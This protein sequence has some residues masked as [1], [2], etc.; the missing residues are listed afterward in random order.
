MGSGKTIVALSMLQNYPEIREVS[1]L[2]AKKGLIIAPAGIEDGFEFDDSWDCNDHNTDKDDIRPPKDLQQLFPYKTEAKA[3]RDS[4]DIMTIRYKNNSYMS[5][6]ELVDG[7]WNSKRG[8]AQ[9]KKS[10]DTLA[11]TLR[12]KIV[13]VDEAHN[14]IPFIRSNR[15]ANTDM[16]FDAFRGAQRVILMSGTPMQRE[17]S[18]ITVLFNMIKKIKPGELNLPTQDE[19]F[20]A[21]YYKLRKEDATTDFSLISAIPELLIRYVPNKYQTLEYGRAALKNVIDVYRNSV[22]GSYVQ[23]AVTAPLVSFARTALESSGWI[24]PTE[25]G[26]QLPYGREGNTNLF[27]LTLSIMLTN[28]WKNLESSSINPVT[29]LT[30][31]INKFDYRQLTPQ[32]LELASELCSFFDYEVA[33]SNPKGNADE[34]IEPRYFFPKENVIDVQVLLTKKQLNYILSFQ[35]KD[36]EDRPINL[37]QSIK[38]LAV[39]QLKPF[40]I[41]EDYVYFGTK[42]GNLADDFNVNNLPKMHGTTLERHFTV[43]NSSKNL[44]SCPKFDYAYAIL[45]EVQYYKPAITRS[46]TITNI[47][48]KYGAP[49]TVTGYDEKTG[50]EISRYDVISRDTKGK[51]ITS[52]YK[53]YLPVVW[54]NFEIEGFAAFG[55]YL[56]A[57][58]H[59]YLVYLPTDTIEERK[60]LNAAALKAYDLRNKNNPICILLHPSITEGISFTFSPALIALE[61]IQGYGVMKQVYGRILRRFN[62]SVST[63]NVPATN[64]DNRMIKYIYQLSSGYYTT[65]TINENGIGLQSIGEINTSRLRAAIDYYK[66]VLPTYLSWKTLAYPNVSSTKLSIADANPEAVQR[67]WNAKQEQIMNKIKNVLKDNDDA[68][69]SRKCLGITSHEKIETHSKCKVCYSGNCDC[70]ETDEKLRLCKNVPLKAGRRRS[71][72]RSPRKS[73]RRRSKNKSKKH[74]KNK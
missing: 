14:L 63:P 16:I 5:F 45:K 26:F 54:S 71:P 44:Y 34:T 74:L 24:A 56:T 21:K 66:G 67:V 9:Q 17:R 58:G 59:K 41:L 69:L 38:D 61:T 15:G 1:E 40:K 32:F 60:A 29:L 4:Y 62:R 68:S 65:H 36:E 64:D 31:W 3:I 8:E 25:S 28:I 7:K 51:I 57:R 19:T 27:D 33:K 37:E 10:I 39:G 11:D 43:K 48:H 22:V 2:G 30:E 50:E 49:R 70:A 12:G 55:A 35:L 47:F 73:Q 53:V 52:A 42:I 20:D 6:A 46:G 23:G 72:Q 13:I 18:D